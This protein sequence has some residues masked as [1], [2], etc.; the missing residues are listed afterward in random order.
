MMPN[1]DPR[2]MRNIMAK[3]GVKSSEVEAKRVI[4]ES[5]TKEIIIENPQVTK[6]E[7]QGNVQFQIA[8]TVSE[9][10]KKIDVDISDDDIKMVADKTGTTDRDLIRQTLIE[11]NGDI[12]AAILRLTKDE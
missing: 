7:M 10:E 11:V 5:D 8:G 12:A 6:I 9:H 3:M 2:T 4:I 1:I